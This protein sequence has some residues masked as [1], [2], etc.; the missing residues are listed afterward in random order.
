MWFAEAQTLREVDLATGTVTTVAG[1][2]GSCATVDGNGS[3]ALFHGTRGLT[4]YD[5]LVYLLDEVEAVLRQYDPV[6]GDVTTIAGT[7]APD[8]DIPQ[9]APYS[10]AQRPNIDAQHGSGGPVS[11][12]VGLS[13]VFDS[14][15]YMTSDMQGGLYIVDTNGRSLLKYNVATREV[16]VLTTGVTASDAAPYNDGAAA[17]TTIDRPRGLVSDGTSLYFAEQNHGTIRQL[18]LT[19]NSTTT[20]VGTQLCGIAATGI[21]DGVGAVTAVGGGS[22]PALSAISS[23]PTFSNSALGA[24]TFHFASR[25]LYLLDAGT[26]RRVQ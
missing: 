3:S 19:N 6:S 25:S 20:F 5:G 13:A 11:A 7:R 23:A 24:I 9:T 17:V 21:R 10:C 12:G 18:D 16:T 15:R 26:L 22:C 4:Y 2:S 1:Q 8:R 14:P